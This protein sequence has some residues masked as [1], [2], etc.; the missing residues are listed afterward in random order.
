[1]IGQNCCGGYWASK[2]CPN[3]GGSGR[4]TYWQPYWHWNNWT[5]QYPPPVPR[6][7]IVMGSASSDAAAARSR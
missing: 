3:C 2:C 5:I 4:V 1:M 6:P 7:Q